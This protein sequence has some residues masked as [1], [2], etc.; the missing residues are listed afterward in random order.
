MKKISLLHVFCAIHLFCHSQDFKSELLRIKEKNNLVGISVCLVKDGKVVFTFNDG[1]RDIDRNLPVTEHTVYRIAS[2]SKMVTVSALMQ[3]YEK[4]LFKLDDD[5]SEYLGFKLRNPNF[6][7]KPVTFQMLMSHT[8]S[9]RDGAGYDNFLSASYTQ[10][11]FPLLSS[12]LVPG[13]VFYTDDIWSKTDAPGCGY[14]QYV[15]LNFGILGTLVER[16]SGE[17][18]DKYCI[19]HIFKPLGMNASFDVR[20]IPDIN[21]MAVL[22]RKEDGKWVP[23][24]DNWRGVRPA[25]RALGD[26]KIGSN[27]VLFAPQGGLRVSAADLT[28]FMIAHMNNGKY[29]KVRIL[30]DSTAK[31][32][33]KVVWSYN[34]NNGFSEKDFYTNYALAFMR[35]DKLVPGVGLIGHS[36][37]AYGLLSGLY[38]SEKDKSG[39][40]FMTN[41][42]EWKP[43]AYSGWQTIEEDVMTA[44]YKFLRSK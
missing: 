13:G 4:G 29:G 12:V 19:D 20:D 8:S 43:G 17:R 23:Q 6:P 5:V 34:G 32:M 14:F 44:C 36:G 40:V 22:Y 33:H 26:Y 38:Y 2:V 9:I 35:T 11:P 10:K 7:D 21:N 41:G 3:L 42:G 30:A 28:K 16:I 18:F 37:D 25:D 39:I 27:A 24:N 15:N 31:R 1:L